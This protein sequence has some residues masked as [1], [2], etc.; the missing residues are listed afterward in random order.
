MKNSDLPAMP[1]NNPETFP[2]PCCE[3]Y[4]KGLTK[5]EMFAMHAMTSWVNHHGS[6]G[7]YSF[8]GNKAARL[9]IECADAL[10]EELAK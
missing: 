8:S 5:R 2:T 3:E 10:L 9:A 1:N 7:D 4:G 6:A